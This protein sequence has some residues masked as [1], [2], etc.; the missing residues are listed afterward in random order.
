ME[1]ALNE[2]L[3]WELY[4]AYLYLSMAAYFEDIGLEGFA[5]LDESPDCRRTHACYEIL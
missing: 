4:S 3:K 2:Q 1:V 5:S